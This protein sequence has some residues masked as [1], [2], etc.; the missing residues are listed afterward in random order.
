MIDIAKANCE[1]AWQ[2]WRIKFEVKDF[3][4]LVQNE[5]LAGTIVTNPPYDLRLKDKNIDS[6]YKNL[7][8]LFRLNPELKGWAI[9]AYT[10]FD[11]LIKLSE[12]KKRK[13]YN[14]WELCYFYRRK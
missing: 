1:R 12:Y 14:G 9:T 10:D 5:K 3:R 7:D 2:E 13:L 6:L 8:K 11:N 4:D